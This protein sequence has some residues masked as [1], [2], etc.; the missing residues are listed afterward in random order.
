[1]SIP[2][3]PPRPSRSNNGPSSN[4]QSVS[5]AAHSVPEPLDR[6]QFARSPLN[7]LPDGF[8]N[9]PYSPVHS[10][11]AHIDEPERPPSVNLPSIGFE[12]E[13]YSTFSPP[14]GSQAPK[15]S[16]N[17][18]KDLPLHQPT[19]AVPASTAK[20]RIQTVTSTQSTN[21]STTASPVIPSASP[22]S[23]DGIHHLDPDRPN[24]LRAR[25]SF[26]QSSASLL[27]A[28]SAD[29]SGADSGIH[30]PM[31]PDAGIVQAP[32]PGPP[33]STP[34]SAALS[35]GFP[36]DSSPMKHHHR[37]AS[38]RQEFGPPGSYGLHGH[39]HEPRDQFERA[40]YQK[41]PEERQKELHRVYDPGHTP[42]ATAMSSD[43]L[44]KLVHHTSETGIGLG[45]D[46]AIEYGQ[47]LTINV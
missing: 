40:W 36:Q 39:L 8:K 23:H 27:S 12:G 29:D 45:K 26:N 43:D 16:R 46:L 19:A 33:T 44:N 37:R 38:S 3:I 25:A 28:G 17:V 11:A 41:H 4:P 42:I 20:S 5:I 1:M 24:A 6:A 30:V 35:S 31:Y 7:E 13:E 22:S 32:S 9:A 2:V 34:G 47:Y 21:P 10:L 15:L 14:P 18:A